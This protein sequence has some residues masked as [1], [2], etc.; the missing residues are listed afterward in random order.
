MSANLRRAG[1]GP[2]STPPRDPLH[3]TERLVEVERQAEASGERQSPPAWRAWS[4][5]RARTVRRRR[6]PPRGGVSFVGELPA[7]QTVAIEVR[8]AHAPPP[9]EGVRI[10]AGLTTIS[11]GPAPASRRRRPVRARCDAGCSPWCQ[12]ARGARA[13]TGRDPADQGGVVRQHHAVGVPLRQQRQHGRDLRRRTARAPCRSGPCRSSPGVHQLAKVVEI[14]GV[15][16]VPDHQPVGGDPA[17]AK[18]ASWSRPLCEG[19]SVWVVIGTPVR[20]RGRGRLHHPF[21]VGRDPLRSV[22][23][24]SMPARTGSR[25]SD[26]D[27]ADEEV[28]QRIGPADGTAGP[29]NWKYS[30]ST[31]A[32]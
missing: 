7:R 11:W 22:T 25:R 8:I 18:N 28:V 31:S 26:L 3:V 1:A 10:R 9:S 19:A 4:A 21:D 12:L 23:T 20:V 30:G 27:V 16:G 14:L 13:M 29:W 24:L 17:R 32:V 2:G 15:A 5:G 6:S